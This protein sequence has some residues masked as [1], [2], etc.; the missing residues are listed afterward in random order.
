M[1]A[2]CIY[3]GVPIGGIEQSEYVLHNL[4]FWLLWYVNMQR[5]HMIILFAI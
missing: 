4:E 2:Y 5:E 1:W 3:I